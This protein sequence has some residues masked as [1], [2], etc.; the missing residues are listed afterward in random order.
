[1]GSAVI[2]T[3]LFHRLP[4]LMNKTEAAV[5][6]NR[7]AMSIVRSLFSRARRISATST[8]VSLLRPWASPVAVRPLASLSA[9]FACLLPRKRWSGSQQSLLSQRCNTHSPGGIGPCR[10]SQATWCAPIWPRPG[11]R[12]TPYPSRWLLATHSR[13]PASD[14]LSL[15]ASRWSTGRALGPDPG[16]WPLT[17]RHGIPAF[18][19]RVALLEPARPGLRPHPHQQYP[20]GMPPGCAPGSC[21][22]MKR[23]IPLSRDKARFP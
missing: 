11:T 7:R 12:S 2:Y 21:V 4:A 13:H 1:M 6:R 23:I 18:S 20:N 19:L 17:Y 5:T 14:L 8:A 10:N 22:A 9:A 3:T 16:V 15:A